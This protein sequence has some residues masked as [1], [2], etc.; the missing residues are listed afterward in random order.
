[1]DNTSFDIEACIRP[2]RVHRGVYVEQAIFEAGLTRIFERTWSLAVTD[3]CGVMV[4]S[5]ALGVCIHSQV[6]G[7]P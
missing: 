6:S 7:P 5:Y 3:A 2:G 4:A 1:V